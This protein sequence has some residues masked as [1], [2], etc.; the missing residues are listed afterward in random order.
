MKY[1]E[2]ITK[3]GHVGRAKYFL[4]HFYIRA[5]DAKDA[6]KKARKI[7]R[8]KHDHKDAIIDVFEI[9]EAAFLSGIEKNMNNPYFVCKNIQEHR[10]NLQLFADD[11]YYE[12]K[13]VFHSRK[14]EYTTDKYIN[15]EKV[16]NHRYAKMRSKEKSYLKEFVC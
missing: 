4:A 15:K 7:P 10:M 9:D 11:I 2:V 12:E 8:V 6:A 3:C 1:F 16:R 13:N 14:T 5:E